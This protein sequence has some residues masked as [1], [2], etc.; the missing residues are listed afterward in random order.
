MKTVIALLLFAVASFSAAEV[1]AAESSTL[2]VVVVDTKD[3]KAYLATL[4]EVK[5]LTATAAPKM[6]VRAWQA[7][8]AG[9]DTGAIIVSVEHPGS[10]SKFASA[11]ESMM[12]DAQIAQKMGELGNLRK[13]VSDSIYQE[14]TL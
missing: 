10:M 13:V 8:Y 12:A 3:L 1:C 4:G 14:L 2:R 7:S 11:W 6:V 5:R 9:P